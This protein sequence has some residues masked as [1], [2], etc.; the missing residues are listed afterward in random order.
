MVATLILSNGVEVDHLR[1]HNT[2]K[3]VLG[4]KFAIDLR[5]VYGEVRWGTENNDEVL[6]IADDGGPTA[7]ITATAIGKTDMIIRTRTFSLRLRIEVTTAPRTT[8]V[9]FAFGNVREREK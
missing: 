4:D 1:D 9:G 6:A 8:S 3:A 2:V 5:G 7:T